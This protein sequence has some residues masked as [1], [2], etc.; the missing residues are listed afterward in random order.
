MKNLG[1]IYTFIVGLGLVVILIMIGVSGYNYLIKGNISQ[2]K[3]DSVGS[4]KGQSNAY[5]YFSDIDE[6]RAD[7]KSKFGEKEMIEELWKN[8]KY[9]YSQQD[10]LLADVRQEANNSIEKITSELNFWVA[11]LAFLGVLV[12]IAITH[13]GEGEAR[14]WLDKKESVYEEKIRNALIGIELKGK[15]LSDLSVRSLSDL[16][17]WSKETED[18]LERSRKEQE[19]LIQ[20]LRTQRDV[21]TLASIRN[22]RYIETDE[23]LRKAYTDTARH[24]LGRFLKNL[25]PQI[26]HYAETD[27]GIEKH[28][29]TR[30]SMLFFDVLNNLKLNHTDPSRPRSLML[31]EESVKQLIKELLKDMPDPHALLDQY[32]EIKI[33]VTRVINQL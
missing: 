5:P 30:M 3:G 27:D 26:D 25:K 9:I 2:G 17:R 11:I 1:W 12:P 24:L 10:N 29:L 18:K 21:E 33:S 20:E 15:Q 22:N 7:K 6:K 19:R 23:E 32:K 8:Q 13:K 28:D 14:N 16:S 31:A 4:S